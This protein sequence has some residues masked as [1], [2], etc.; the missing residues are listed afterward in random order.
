MSGCRMFMALL[1]V[2]M[3]G[4]F[5]GLFVLAQFMVM[6]CLSMMVGGSVVMRGGLMVMLARRILG[7][8]VS[9]RFLFLHFADR[10]LTKL[11]WRSDDDLFRR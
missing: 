7:H 4:V 11:S 3:S 1:A 5:F 6:G 2:F 8:R 9:F 10:G